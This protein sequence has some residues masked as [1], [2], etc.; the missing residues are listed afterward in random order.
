MKMSDVL[1][2]KVSIVTGAGSGIGKGI[3]MALANAGSKVI[4]V[5]RTLDK[6]EK[7]TVELKQ[8][9]QEGIAVKADVSKEK[10]VESMVDKAVKSYGRI[11]I[12]V[13]NAGQII[14]SEIVETKIKDWD[15]VLNTNLRGTFLCSRAVMRQM[16]IQKSGKI[17]NIS[18]T[19]G[20][21]GYPARTAY[22]ASKFGVSGFNESLAQEAAK[23]S[24]GVSS[25]CPGLVATEMS[26]SVFPDADT[27]EW[28]SPE[29]IGEVV[30]FLVTRPSKVLIP[31]MVVL[32][33]KADYYRQ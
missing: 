32:A 24:I 12:L 16:K 7:V 20:K 19:G 22:C 6:L 17:I 13:N 5:G 33:S 25:I 21:H 2:D 31:E 23:Y 10:D 9:G 26:R 30:V 3:T 4:V 8:A 15:N 11:D 28:L 29:D 27:S 18:S 1:N 14:G